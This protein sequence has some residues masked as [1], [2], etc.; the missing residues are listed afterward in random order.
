MKKNP[1][2]ATLDDYKAFQNEKVFGT[3]GPNMHP[4]LMVNDPELIKA[5]TV[6]DFNHFVDRSSTLNFQSLG[7]TEI[8][9]AWKQ[10]LTALQGNAWKDV[11]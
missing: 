5:I 1:N 10:Q 2:I 11:R 6:K 4:I 8:D 7:N 9:S 3:Y